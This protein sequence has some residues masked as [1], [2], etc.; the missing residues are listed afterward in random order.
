MFLDEEL[1]QIGRNA[2]ITEDGINKAIKEMVRTCFRDIHKR[3]TD[4][5]IQVMLASFK[6][7]NNTWKKV[8]KILDDEKRGFIRIDGFEQLVR[9]NKEFEE[10]NFHSL[11]N[12]K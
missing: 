5:P 8:A 3:S 7:V 10:I 9:H 2:P 6:R 11:F 12:P 4:Q 1:L